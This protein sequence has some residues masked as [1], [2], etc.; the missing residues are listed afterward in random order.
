[1]RSSA[2]APR[3]IRSSR[4]A[5]SGGGMPAPGA[6]G[7]RRGSIYRKFI[8]SYRSNI[9]WDK[10]PIIQAVEHDRKASD[11][12][13]WVGQSMIAKAGAYP[14]ARGQKGRECLVTLLIGC[15]GSVLSGTRLP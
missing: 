6:N 7:L 11:Y 14:Y 12:N 13:D 10:L 3:S 5:S 15:V 4:P 8:P 1:M 9:N 2:M